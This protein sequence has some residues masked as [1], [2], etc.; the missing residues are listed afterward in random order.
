MSRAPIGS[1]CFKYETVEGDSI[2][3]AML[4]TMCMDINNGLIDEEG[5]KCSGFHINHA[6]MITFVF[7]SDEKTSRSSLST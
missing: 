6:F 2:L 5:G 3:S 4:G 1:Y 7:S